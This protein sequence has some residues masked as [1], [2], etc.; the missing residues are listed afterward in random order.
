MKKIL[1]TIALALTCV[2]SVFAQEPQKKQDNDLAGNLAKMIGREGVYAFRGKAADIYGRFNNPAPVFYIFPDAA[3]TN[4]DAAKLVSES[5]MQE[6]LDEFAGSAY[7]VNPLGA[8]YDN[9]K[10]LEAFIQ[11]LERM[12]IMF[13]VKVIGIGN[14]ATFVNEAIARKAG[15]IADIV[16]IGGKAPKKALAGESPVPAYI[17]GKGA[18]KIAANYIS[19][20]KVV[21]KEK[22]GKKSVYVNPDEPLMKVVVNDVDASDFKTVFADAWEDLLSW[23]YRY[24]NYNHTWYNGEKYGEHGDSELEPFLIFD[25]LG[26]TRNVCTEKLSGT[27]TYLWYEYLPESVKN[28]P[29]GTVPLVVLLH[30]NNN[31]PRTQAETSGFLPL[32]S[33]EGFMVA[34][35]EWQGNGWEAMGHDGIETVIYALFNKYPQIDRSRVYAEGLSAGAFTA[36]ALG[37]KKTHV[38]AAVGAQSGGI[39]P[40]FRFGTG[41]GPVFDEATLKSEGCDMP[42]FSISGSADDVVPISSPKQKISSI[43][44]AWQAYSIINNLPAVGELDFDVDKWFGMKLENRKRVDT[45]KGISYEMGDLC[46]AGVP[47][48]RAVIVDGYAHWNF[49]PGA[50]EMWN[51]F[52]L[53]SRDEKTKKLIYHGK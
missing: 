40:S 15:S 34:E 10:D 46:K 43:Y 16:T 27:G 31:D 42:Y 14:G 20:D 9:E 18:A 21:L 51:Y 2:V 39:M 26:I 53:F 23:N 3:M 28:A 37:I 5:G 47:L 35:F 38:F 4:D 49:Q 6:V 19:R 41:M 1:L 8:K 25:R 52:K 50:E 48:V 12:R 45:N 24:N 36:T 44:Y 17:T 22:V 13:N 32:A 11:L 7:I 29:A 30:G 33:R